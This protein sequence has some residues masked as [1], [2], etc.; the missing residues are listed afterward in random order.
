MSN[1]IDQRVVQM[2]FDNKQ[3]ESGVQTSLS[4]LDKLN[5]KL[6]FKDTAKNI[7]SGFSSLNLGF[8]GDAIQSIADKFTL[9][10]VIGQTVF[11]NLANSVVSFGTKL[12]TAIPNQIKTGGWNRALNLE[13]AQFQLEGLGVQWDTIKEDINYGV[14]DTAYSLDAAAKAAAQLV[15][16]GIDVGDSMKQALRGISGVAAQTNSSYEEIS[17]VFTRIAG[18]GRVY[19]VDLQSLSSRGLNAAAILA[20]SFGTTEAAVRDMVSD[21]EI[22]FATFSKVMDEAF[23]QNATKANDTFQGSL[24][25]VKAALSKVGAEFANPLLKNSRDI[26][27]S[28]RLA[29]NKLRAEL[30]PF[31]DIFTRFSNGVTEKIIETINKFDIKGLGD[32]FG[33]LLKIFD[34]YGDVTPNFIKHLERYKEQLSGLRK[35]I[36]KLPEDAQVLIETFGSLENAIDKL[37][38]LENVRN[39]FKGFLSILDLGKQIVDGFWRA[40]EPLR[41]LFGKLARVILEGTGSLGKWVSNLSKTTKENDTF[42]NIFKNIV[43]FIMNFAQ[44]AFDGLGKAIE[45]VKNVTKPL[46]DVF[47]DAGS[48]IG[49]FFN[50]FSSKNNK[51]IEGSGKALEAFKIVLE[52]IGDILGDFIGLFKGGLDKLF[53]GFSFDKLLKIVETG[54]LLKLLDQITGFVKGI[55]NL[56]E[57]VSGIT[58]I[59][60]GSGSKESNLMSIAKALLILTG[61]LVIL[62]SIDEEKLEKAGKAMLGLFTDLYAS[63][64]IISKMPKTGIKDSIAIVNELLGLSTSMLILSASLRIIGGMDEQSLTNSINVMFGVFTGLLAITGIISKIKINRKNIKDFTDLVDELGS[65]AL[66][67]SISLN[68]V[69]VAMKIFASAMKTFGNM[70]WEQIEKGILSITALIGVFGA[71]MLVLNEMNVGAGQMI[72]TAASLTIIGVAMLEFAGVLAILSLLSWDAISRGL[73]A[74]G[75]GL[76]EFAISAKIMGSKEA[77]AGAAGILLMSASLIALVPAL[78]LLGSMS[79]EAIGKSLIALGGALLAFITAAMAIETFDLAETILSIAGAILIFGLGLDAIALSISLF[80]AGLTALGAAITATGS[81]II[82]GLTNLI[83]TVSKSIAAGILSFAST[84]ADG[85]TE[86]VKAVTKLVKALLKALRIIIPDIIETA[87]DIIIALAETIDSKID[88]IANTAINI[89]VTF[90]ET[91]ASRID[92][93]IDAALDLMEAFINGLADG[94]R[95]HTPTILGAVGNL[96]SAILE[97]ALSA[98]QSVVKLI[99]VIGDKLN[100]GLETAKGAIRETLAPDSMK[101]IGKEATKGAVDGITSEFDNKQS[102]IKS[103]AQGAKDNIISGLDLLGLKNLT[104]TEMGNINSNMLSKFKMSDYS[105]IGYNIAHSTGDSIYNNSSYAENAAGSMASRALSRAKQALGIASPSK[106]FEEVGKFTDMGFAK[107]ID[108]YSGLV[109]EASTTV[110]NDTLNAIRNPLAHIA[111]I[112]S[113]EIDINPTISPVLDLSEIKSGSKNIKDIFTSSPALALAGVSG[114]NSGLYNSFGTSTNND[115]M[116]PNI[117]ITINASENQSVDE[118]YEVFS[119]RMTIEMQRGFSTWK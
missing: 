86:L 93:I 99:P 78:M 98:L 12:L 112:L 107:G 36:D 105:A 73:T 74:I 102:T 91:I 21:G 44:P 108:K 10:G 4:T 42:Y 68:L 88:I 114:F 61:S 8:V 118:L 94:I 30:D 87:G 46:V 16:S 66:K 79:I 23:G 49:N 26:L 100:D 116:S 69:G 83:I 58:S 76:A 22:N 39:T 101:E 51:N 31:V 106:E 71:L 34:K 110:A 47:S 89:V 85:A 113:K 37:E 29:V 3:F 72:A 111:D 33:T 38:I 5:D 15:S 97:F 103:S 18:N 109:D 115:S 65:F 20:K 54:V 92:E 95:V 117:N 14:Q 7:E 77:L 62:A 2:Q 59:F 67:F 55:N 32:K 1:S 35:S 28:F 52:A 24:S 63:M 6:R 60:K 53:D 64:A 9:M 96:M 27:N 75:V 104:S 70:E 56:G 84:I 17:H 57:Q 11:H 40:T 50:K 13:N 25:N 119:N 90:L 45:F 82:G 19:A 43:D 80:A 41:E 81:I 48:K